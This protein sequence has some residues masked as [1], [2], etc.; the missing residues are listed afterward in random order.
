M[1]DKST[2]DILE[3]SKGEHSLEEVVKRAK[4]NLPWYKRKTPDRKP[5]KN[6]EHFDARQRHNTEED[7]LRK[8]DDY[9]YINWM[10]RQFE[11]KGSL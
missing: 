10:N 1:N 4:K 7:G 6:M 8:R 9:F 11:A 5:P 2:K 3:L